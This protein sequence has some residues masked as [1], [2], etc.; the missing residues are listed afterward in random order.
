MFLLG[1]MLDSIRLINILPSMHV[2][3]PACGSECFESVL[4]VQRNAVQLAVDISAFSFIGDATQ[5]LIDARVGLY[6]KGS[7][8]GPHCLLDCQLRL[9]KVV[10]MH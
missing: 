3:V 2:H 4:E 7:E 6:P 9:V 5:K 10:D 8:A 1:Q